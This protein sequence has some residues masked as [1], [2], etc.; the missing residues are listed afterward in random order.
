MD[1]MVVRHRYPRYKTSRR[2]RRYNRDSY[3]FSQKVALQVV[4]CLVILGAALGIKYLD[5]SYTA[6]LRGK[7]TAMVSQDVEVQGLF[8]NIN[9]FLNTVINNST[10]R[11]NAEEG[12]NGINTS[13]DMPE[14]LSGNSSK[15]SGGTTDYDDNTNPIVSG[16]GIVGGINNETERLSKTDSKQNISFKFIAPVEGPVSSPF[17]ERL[18]P[19]RKEQAFHRGVDIEANKGAAIK[20]IMDGEIIETG[21]EKTLGNFVRIKHPLGFTSVYAHCSVLVSQKGQKVNQGEV[22]AKVGD[23]GASVGSHLHLELW[24]DGTAIDP[25]LYLSFK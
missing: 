15:I 12:N 5:T 23:T 9:S 2:K 18:H 25:Q 8:E 17:G 19:I 13:A 7:I 14:E 24:K 22:I 3:D 20:A 10:K 1:D 11:K 4:I 16:Q 6:Y 21:S